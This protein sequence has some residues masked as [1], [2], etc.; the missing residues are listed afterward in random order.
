M[1]LRHANLNHSQPMLP[2]YTRWRWWWW[3]G[4]VKIVSKEKNVKILA[5]FEE[6]NPFLY[7]IEIG[8]SRP[9]AKIYIKPTIY[10]IN[11]WF[12]DDFTG[13]KMETLQRIWLKLHNSF[14]LKKIKPRQWI[15]HLSI[16]TLHNCQKQLKDK[17][18]KRKKTKEKKR[19]EKNKRKKE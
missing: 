1:G 8:S 11:V 2:F 10:K 19:K 14:S 16:G 13:Y 9:R 15:T 18:P 17:Q 5:L 12:S 4:D 7:K 6:N 3:K